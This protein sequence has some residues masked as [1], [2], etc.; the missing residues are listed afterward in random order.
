MQKEGIQL[1][2]HA[3]LLHGGLVEQWS[4]VGVVDGWI[5]KSRVHHLMAN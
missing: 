1:K 4:D 5:L 3:F 2:I